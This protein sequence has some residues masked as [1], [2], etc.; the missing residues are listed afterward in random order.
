MS[1]I[2]ISKIVR[3]VLLVIPFLMIGCDDFKEENYEADEVDALG[4]EAISANAYATALSPLIITWVDS[5]QLYSMI[6]TELSDTSNVATLADVVDSLEKYEIVANP[7]ESRIIESFDTSG[8]VINTD[9]VLFSAVDSKIN[10]LKSDV[11]VDSFHVSVPF[12]NYLITV[13]GNTSGYS[14]LF[15]PGMSGKVQFYADNYINVVVT[16][17]N[18]MDSTSIVPADIPLEL[19]SSYY[20]VE[21][22][23]TPDPVLKSYFSMNMENKNYI[24]ALKKTEATVSSGKVYFS[25]VTE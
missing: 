4:A 17:A 18:T 21:N 19:I 8:T 5:L 25:F 15:N 10:Q 14:F 12:P 13:G 1:I 9:T 22:D 20:V 23:Q 2:R 16:E 7:V 3:L 11:E 24:I 6:N